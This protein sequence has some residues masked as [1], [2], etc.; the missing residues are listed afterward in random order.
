VKLRDLDRR[1]GGATTWVV[2][3]IESPR[4]GDTSEGA[5][6]GVLES[7]ARL[8]NRLLLRIDV[9]GRRRTASLEWASPPGVSDVE[10][11]LLASIGTEI[12]DLGNLELP[13]RTGLGSATPSSRG[14]DRA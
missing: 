12:R 5:E 10:A 13:T 1:P 11:V 2:R 8:G 6:E 9:G 7:V 3:W 14:R 4:P